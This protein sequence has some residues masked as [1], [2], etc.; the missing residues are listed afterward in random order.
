MYHNNTC[1]FI[2]AL[3]YSNTD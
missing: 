1:T 3:Y 2:V